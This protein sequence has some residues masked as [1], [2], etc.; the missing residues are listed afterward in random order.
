MTVINI[1]KKH[2]LPLIELKQK[3]DSIII[4]MGKRLE[5]NSEWENE[6]SLIFKRK[7]ASGN[8]EIDENNFELTL[9]LGLMYK[10]LKGVIHSEISAAVSKKLN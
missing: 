6:Y 2:Q 4:E 7:G 1:K 3:I 5:F 9:R 8:I 10:S